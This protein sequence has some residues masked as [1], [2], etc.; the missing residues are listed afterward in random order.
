MQDEAGMIDAAIEAVKKA[1]QDL[2]DTPTETIA[3]NP[4]TKKEM[5]ELKNHYQAFMQKLEALKENSAVSTETAVEE[6]AEDITFS[7]QEFFAMYMEQIFI[8]I[9]NGDIEPTYQI[10]SQFFTEKE[11]ET[12]LEKFDSVEEAIQELI[13]EEQAREEAEEAKTENELAGF[14]SAGNDIDDGALLTAE[15]TSCKYE[16][17]KP[18]DDDILYVTFYTAEGIRCKKLGAEDFEW[19]LTFENKEQYNKVMEFLE[20]FP[21]DW[22]M[23]FAAHKNFWQDFLNDEIDMDAFMEFMESTNEGVP[24]YSVTEGDSVY[25]D[26]EKAQ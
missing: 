2:E 3:N 20:N 13:K 15:T 12:F 24:D 1:L 22:N 23:R 26:E 8:K 7:Y 6:T 10:G 4:D 9:Q 11:W 16:T 19:T 21:S 18:E 5:Q 25:V 14:V 17:A